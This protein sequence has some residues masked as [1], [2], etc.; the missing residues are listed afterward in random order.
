[1]TFE[2]NSY[3]QRN[4]KHIKYENDDIDKIFNIQGVNQ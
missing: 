4:D 3:N 1:M 2:S